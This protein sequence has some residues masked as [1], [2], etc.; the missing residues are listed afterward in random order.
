MINEDDN[1]WL[2][3]S[4]YFMYH[5]SIKIFYFLNRGRFFYEA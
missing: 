2:Q 5:I 1:L 3:L 4:E